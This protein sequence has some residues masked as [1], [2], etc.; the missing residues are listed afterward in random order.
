MFRTNSSSYDYGRSL[1]D[2]AF[3]NFKCCSLFHSFPSSAENFTI[4]QILWPLR[5]ILKE[6]FS[7]ILLSAHIHW[8]QNPRHSYTYTSSYVFLYFRG[9]PFAIKIFEWRWINT[10]SVLMYFLY[11]CIN[12]G[13]FCHTAPDNASVNRKSYGSR[14]IEERQLREVPW[15]VVHKLG[16][17]EKE[18]HKIKCIISKCS[19]SRLEDLVNLFK[20]RNWQLLSQ[21]IFCVSWKTQNT[22]QIEM[23]C[24]DEGRKILWRKNDLG[25]S[26]L[27]PLF[28]GHVTLSVARI[29]SFI[30]PSKICCL[31]Q[32]DLWA[33]SLPLVAFFWDNLLAFF[34]ND[35]EWYLFV[36]TM[37]VPLCFVVFT[38]AK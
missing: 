24:R 30:T 12:N 38:C 9:I 1:E 27:G 22:R 10:F 34:S 23:G 6:S 16:L 29:V 37:S 36:S 2:T 31:F 3:N 17:L 13:N 28:V 21:S 25:C 14:F 35:I 7:D 15:A 18:L 11:Y 32:V 8:L 20:V 26:G 5:L 4:Y 19:V 33:F